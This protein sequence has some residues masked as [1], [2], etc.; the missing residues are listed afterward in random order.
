MK[1][2]V[3]NIQSD[4]K[5]EIMRFNTIA[6]QAVWGLGLVVSTVSAVAMAENVYVIAHPSVE[7]SQFEVQQVYKGEQ[8]FAGA[9]KLVPVDNAAVQSDFLD[10]A[11][12][13]DAGKYAAL[14]IKKG[15]RAALTAPST[16]SGDTEVINF[17]RNTRG[18][19][20]YVG[21]PSDDVKLLH[22]Y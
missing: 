4:S 1:K 11:M 17:I 19:V 13:M 3:L 6:K 15:F 10:K 8:E 2:S 12:H 9:I 16:K 7:L 5:G 21:A 18:A 14:W 22:K 20:G